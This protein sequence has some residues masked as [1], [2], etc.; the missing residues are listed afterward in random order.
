MFSNYP[1]HHDRFLREI[2]QEVKPVYHI[3]PDT[4]LFVDEK[5]KSCVLKH[6]DTAKVLSKEELDEYISSLESEGMLIERWWAG[7]LIVTK[8][9]SAGVSLEF[10]SHDKMF[11]SLLKGL[12]LT[13]F[14][15][16]DEEGGFS[17]GENTFTR[18]G[19][20][21]IISQEDTHIEL[22]NSQLFKLLEEYYAVGHSI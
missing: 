3:D 5:N 14:F 4:T 2:Q 20:L 17:A 15:D 9:G 13:G 11:F 22:T 8:E 7:N 18:S 10:S 16:R 21:N 6:K 1:E 19:S 12:K